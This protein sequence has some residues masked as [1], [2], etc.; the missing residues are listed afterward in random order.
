QVVS[1]NLYDL[2]GV[3]RYQQGSAETPWRWVW[4]QAGE[5]GLRVSAKGQFYLPERM[6]VPL[7]S[8]SYDLHKDCP[9]SQGGPYPRAMCDQFV[10][11]CIAD[12]NSLLEQ[13]ER[14]QKAFCAS[15][16]VICLFL[17][18]PLLKVFCFIV[19]MVCSYDDSCHARYSGTISWC[20]S[21][22][23]TCV[24]NSR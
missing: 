22:F 15:V 9:F 14:K 7:Y 8:S 20:M 2:F 10:K 6:I 21:C 5:E 13:C 11:G 3:L 16:G 4:I 24:R 18:G 1:N 23:D 17:P 12:A 19:G